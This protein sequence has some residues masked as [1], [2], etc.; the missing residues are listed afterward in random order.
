VLG[1]IVQGW[2]RE[3][4]VVHRWKEIPRNGRFAWDAAKG[5]LQLYSL[6]GIKADL[7]NEIIRTM[8][9]LVDGPEPEKK[10]L[11]TVVFAGHRVDEAGREK[12]RF[13]PDSETK[14]R[15]TAQ[16]TKWA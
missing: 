6:L 7:A 14:A 5:Q 1:R 3:C 16:A 9:A 2:G 13:P 15:D 10:V 12:P 4:E 8:D 11:H